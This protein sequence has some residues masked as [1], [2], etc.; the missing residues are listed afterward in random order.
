MV[1][2]KSKREQWIDKECQTNL[3]KR[4]YVYMPWMKDIAIWKQIIEMKIRKKQ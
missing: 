4:I 1:Y 2:D 3:N